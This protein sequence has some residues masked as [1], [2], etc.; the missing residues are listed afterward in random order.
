MAL[1]SAACPHA[2]ESPIAF[3]RPCP[4]RTPDCHPNA[5]DYSS[6]MRYTTVEVVL[7]HGYVRPKGHDTLPQSA[8]ALL[9]VLED[10]G[11]SPA[12][13]RSLNEPGLQRLLSSPPRNLTPEQLRLSMET[14]VFDQ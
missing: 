8:F 7:E 6:E 10:K 1:R 2:A 11:E 13:V 3:F 9:T 14:D 5:N 12:Q 4:A